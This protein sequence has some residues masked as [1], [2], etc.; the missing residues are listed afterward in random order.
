MRSEATAAA[1]HSASGSAGGVHL[2]DDLAVLQRERIAL[3]EEL[4]TPGAPNPRDVILD[5][6]LSDIPVRLQSLRSAAA[7]DDFELITRTAHSIKGASANIGALRVAELAR[8]VELAAS[9]DEL[10]SGAV[11]R[12]LE[13]EFERL[14]GFILSE[15]LGQ[16]GE[17]A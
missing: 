15:V 11:L 14:R 3:L 13:E 1:T 10:P 17:D 7:A 16:A 6:Y 12:A 2:D 5:V 4:A 8:R 9:D